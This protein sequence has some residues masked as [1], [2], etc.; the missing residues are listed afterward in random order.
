MGPFAVDACA[1]EAHLADYITL[2]DLL[3][4][5]CRYGAEVRVERV[6]RAA[7]DVVTND[8]IATVV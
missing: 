8:D 6:N 2:R 7:V 4:C 1:G 5:L 3:S